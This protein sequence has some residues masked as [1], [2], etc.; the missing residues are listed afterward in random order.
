MT[1]KGHKSEMTPQKRYLRLQNIKAESSV[2]E[3]VNANLLQVY[4]KYAISVDQRKFIAINNSWSQNSWNK[5]TSL[6]KNYLQ[7]LYFLFIF[8]RSV[9]IDK[10]KFMSSN[11]INC[12]IRF[13]MIFFFILF[14]ADIYYSSAARNNKNKWNHVF[15]LL[16]QMSF[17]GYWAW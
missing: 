3:T 11:N 2:F 7:F 4:E 10:K 9:P 8:K 17:F 5:T 14:S 6:M 16:N 13:L 12:F 1:P 15:K